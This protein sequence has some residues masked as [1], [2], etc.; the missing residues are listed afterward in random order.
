MK[1]YVFLVI[2]ILIFL[3]PVQSVFAQ[4]RTG[5]RSNILDASPMIGSGGYNAPV[6]RFRYTP[7]NLFITG[8]VT[9]GKAFRGFVPYSSPTQ[10]Q[11]SLGSSSLSAFES[12]SV[13]LQQIRSGYLYGR[14]GPYFNPSSTILPLS[15]HRFASPGSSMPKLSTP[16]LAPSFSVGA[17]LVRPSEIHRKQLPR[18]IRPSDILVPSVAI[19]VYSQ[20]IQPQKSEEQK[21]QELKAAGK[22]KG[23]EKKIAPPEEN[24]PL[25]EPSPQQTPQQGS[26]QEKQKTQQDFTEF[27]EQQAAHLPPENTSLVPNKEF[28]ES[29]KRLILESK[30]HGLKKGSSTQSAERKTPIVVTSLAGESK[31]L[32]SRTMRS[33]QQMLNQ[34]RFFFAYQQYLRAAE[35]K[36]KDPMPLFGQVHSLVAAGK[37]RLAAEVLQVAIDKFPSFVRLRLS[38]ERL[39]GSRTV[40]HRRLNQLEDLANKYS[41]NKQIKFLLGYF[42]ILSG[43]REQGMALMKKSQE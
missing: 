32:F 40:L 14:P 6:R 24:Q 22:E 3:V 41:T 33:A 25:M 5:V 26:E 43:D 20:P 39:I 7:G 18:Q 37:F 19:D 13:N 28:A 12:E 1:K 9:G 34:G 10:F 36:P 16:K 11:G 27:L 29:A 21:A 31:D 23:T 38:G 42:K 17:V 35:I 8:N 2:L 30:K 4:R 15:A